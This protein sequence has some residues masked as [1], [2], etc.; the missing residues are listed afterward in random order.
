MDG[1]LC[2]NTYNPTNTTP[3]PRNISNTNKSPPTNPPAVLHHSVPTPIFYPRHVEQT[4]DSTGHTYFLYQLLMPSGITI[5]VEETRLETYAPT[6][7]P[8]YSTNPTPSPPVHV[9]GVAS[10]TVLPSIPPPPVQPHLPEPPNHAPR[11]PHP[12]FTPQ[13][14]PP[15]Q[16]LPPL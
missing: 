7:P 11:L 9:P 6:A 1:R 3:T 12:T 14:T 15:P 16:H 5:T 8:S 2:Y 13:P 10:L 4:T